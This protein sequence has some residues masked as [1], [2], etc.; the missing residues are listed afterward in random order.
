MFPWTEYKVVGGYNLRVPM[1]LLGDMGLSQYLN[2]VDRI[3]FERKEF[4]Y[5]HCNICEIPCPKGRDMGHPY[6]S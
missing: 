5:R 1:S 6:I 4:G 2:I 3:I